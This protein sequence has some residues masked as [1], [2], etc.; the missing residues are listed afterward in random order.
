MLSLLMTKR[1]PRSHSGKLRGCDSAER[2][3]LTP[4]AGQWESLWSL[5]KLLKAVSMPCTHPHAP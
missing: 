3:F 2:R 5:A 4:K 1:V